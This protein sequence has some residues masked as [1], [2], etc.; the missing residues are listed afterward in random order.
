MAS[1]VAAELFDESEIAQIYGGAVTDQMEAMEDLLDYLSEG[2][3][4]IMDML[5]VGFDIA[6]TASMMK[7][8][9]RT[10]RNIENAGKK[11]QKG[12][13]L[14]RLAE[15][16]RRKGEAQITESRFLLRRRNLHRASI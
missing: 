16:L 5:K 2:D 15:K 11:A 8:M 4:V 1:Q 12:L 14:L 9:G 6:C 10:N 13:L 7:L 3:Q